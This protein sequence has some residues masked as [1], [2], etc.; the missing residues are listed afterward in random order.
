MKGNK[1]MK[2]ITK[3][4]YAVF[5]ALTLAIGAVTAN[6]AVNDLFVSINGNG[7]NGGGSVYEYTPAGFQ[8]TFATGLSRPRGV[9]F[10]S[11]GNLL[12]A[13]STFDNVNQVWV[14]TIVKI[15]PD[16]VHSTFASLGNYFLEGV[17]LDQLGNVFVIADNIASPGVTIF[18]ITPDGVPGTFA[19]LTSIQ[20]FGLAFDR[21]GFLYAAQ[22]FDAAASEIW[23]FAPDG[24]S[25]LFATASSPDFDLSD[26]A[27]DSFGNLF[28]SAG[29]GLGQSLILKYA[30][31]STESTF[32]TGLN[33]V[34]GL[35]F[36]NGGNLFLADVLGGN[37]L[38]F[39]PAGTRSVFVS[40]IAAPEFLAVQF[41]PTPHPRPSPHPRPL[42][43]P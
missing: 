8:S 33:S 20:S 36:G 16:G 42:L 29:N 11:S 23:K 5:G 30:P 18:K 15:T 35:A 26:L 28:V 27:F 39:T 1:H 43:L 34:R 38:K 3:F 25:S 37:I 12:V 4:T 22:N 31:D 13:T 2:T 14:G 10:D 41:R 40:G 9:A 19:S 21:T 32:A 6:G 17:A 24:T 7:S